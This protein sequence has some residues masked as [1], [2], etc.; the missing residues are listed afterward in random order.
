MEENSRKELLQKIIDSLCKLSDNQ[1]AEF[2]RFIEA[3]I[4]NAS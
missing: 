1:I 3:G 4:E 2:K